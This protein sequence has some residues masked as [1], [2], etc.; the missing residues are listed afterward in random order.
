MGLPTVA[1]VGRPN[2]GKSSLLNT[3]I[4]RR[5]SIVDPT[6]GVTR[7]RV[8]A[9]CELAEHGWVELVDTGGMG[10]EDAD[11]LTDHV[12][13]QITYG[14]AAADLVLFVVDAREGITPL[15]VHVAERLRRENKPVLLLANKIDEAT[16]VSEAGEM[17]ALGFGKPME[18]SAA[19]NLG[20]AELRDA[21]AAQ[22]G[23]KMMPQRPE[24]TVMKVAL[25]GKRNAG[26][27]TFIN[28]LAGQQR[29]IVS[30][31]PGTTRD[32]VDVDVELDGRQFTLIDT[33]GLRK[34]KSFSGDLEFY[35]FTRAMG[36]IGRADVVLFMIDASVKISQV[37]KKLAQ[38][39]AEQH[40]PVVFVV[41]KWDLAREFAEIDDYSEYLDK[42]F[43]LLSF[44]PISLTTASQGLNV[45][46]TIRL[47]EQVYRQ[48]ATRMST[49]DLNNAIQEILQLR[50]PSHKAGTKPP[51]ILYGSQI[52]TLPPT[53][54]LFVNDVRSFDT[55]YQRFLL[56]QLRE[57]TPF[58]EV[59]I[60][61][62][63]RQR[64]SPEG[65]AIPPGVQKPGPGKG[66]PS[67]RRGKAAGKPPRKGP[68]RSGPRRRK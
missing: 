66:A 17:F 36:S 55:S 30:E 32:S 6:P 4:G 2:V 29:V 8:A 58:A 3:L 65:R 53:L 47:A 28:A 21:I 64:R 24:R 59:P 62:I 54:V 7:D 14:I 25:V 43:P 22:L 44:A 40:K 57:R 26:K 13:S 39:I 19:H 27:S 37:D 48:A 23:E 38:E 20:I 67:R 45:R 18:I 35:S 50:G 61:L 31:T 9:A 12:E 63:L 41:N 60:N 1:I 52:A 33:A 15:D 10:I 5:I 51:K 34:R 56:N 11:Q 68:G 46:E 42:V 49:G 16:L